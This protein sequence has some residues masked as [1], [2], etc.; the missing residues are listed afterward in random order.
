MNEY[1]KYSD[2]NAVI[3]KA[4]KLL[5][6]IEEAYAKS[7][8]E[9][10]ISDEL[11]VEIKDY[12]GN[13]RS[14]LDYLRGKVSKYNFPVCKT[15]AEFENA[16]TDLSEDTKLAIKK[17]QP[18]N[19]NEWLSNFNLLNNKSKHIT[20][21]PQIRREQKTMTA[22]TDS[23]SVTMPIDNPNFSVQQGSNCQVTLGGV[24]VRF[25]NQGI[26]PLAPGLQREITTWVSFSFDNSSFPEL[27]DK[28]NVL[29]FLK[30]CFNNITKA[31]SEIEST[32]ED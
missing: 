32:I 5:D 26:T 16:T 22:K 12:L 9:K 17:W 3:K 14:S 7:L 13:L 1:S 21:I 24:P 25:S 18:F 19:G 30:E 29:P 23:V 6:E 15:E 28:I 27:S 20:L 4:K 10:A 2:I 31:V 8:N 11:M